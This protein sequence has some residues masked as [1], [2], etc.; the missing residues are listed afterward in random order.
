MCA[1]GDAIAEG[2]KGHGEDVPQKQTKPALDQR[3]HDEAEAERKLRRALFRA[4]KANPDGPTSRLVAGAFATIAVDRVDWLAY[5]MVD[6]AL[7]ASMKRRPKDVVALRA[8]HEHRR[9]RVAAVPLTIIDIAPLVE[10][11]AHLYSRREDWLPTGRAAVEALERDLAARFPA[12]RVPSVEELE[13]WISRHSPKG[14][15]DKPSAARIVVL[16]I[17]AA[18][19]PGA[20][21]SSEALFD[22]ARQVLKRHARVERR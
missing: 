3:K 15:R 21:S 10:R 14:A 7:R 16:I 17:K 18:R 1:P 19:L 22:N 11:A 5:E 13:G 6:A 12:H 8:W 4:L 2:A 9:R 20:S